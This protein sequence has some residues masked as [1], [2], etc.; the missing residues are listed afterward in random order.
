MRR[1]L[2]AILTLIGFLTLGFDFLNS[3]FG[4][5]DGSAHALLTSACFF[6][7]AL[8]LGPFDEKRKR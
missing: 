2:I 4:G 6:L 7:A 8:S 1:V 5:H 3:L